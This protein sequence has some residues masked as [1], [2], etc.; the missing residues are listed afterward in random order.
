MTIGLFL[1]ALFPGLFWG[2][3]SLLNSKLGGTAAQQTLGMTVGALVFGWVVTF[4]YVLPNHIYF[5]SK[6]WILG[7][8]SGLFWAVGTAGQFAANKI[9]GVS[10]SIPISV[11]FQLVFNALAAAIILGEWTTAKK[12][13]VGLLSI[14]LIVAGALLI[15]AKS[16]AQKQAGETLSGLIKGVSILFI[17]NFGYVLYFMFPNLMH[18]NGFISESIY[19]AKNGIG[20]MTSVVGPQSIGQVIGA[21][22]IVIF[23]FKEK[24]LI[25]K[26]PTAKNILVGLSWG[27]GNLFMYIASSNPKIGQAVASTLPQWGVILSAF[28]GVYLLHEHKD[29]SQMVKILIGSLLIVAGAFLI[30]LS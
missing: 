16:K 15:S 7:I 5:G 22:L 9:L 17:S 1:L 10:V 21:L 3:I 14:A 30:G 6:I 11:T 28:G 26:T 23:I 20:Y 19:N 4:A 27:I 8:I 2:S 29:K 12:W 25:F 18:K 24:E 13:I